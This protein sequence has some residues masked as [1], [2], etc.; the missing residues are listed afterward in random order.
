MHLI[1]LSACAHYGKYSTFNF[2]LDG[3]IQYL[4]LQLI[5]PPSGVHVVATDVLSIT[6]TCVHVSFKKSDQCMK[7]K[8]CSFLN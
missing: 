7:T 5:T 3:F 1:T 2:N 8:A 4:I 6:I